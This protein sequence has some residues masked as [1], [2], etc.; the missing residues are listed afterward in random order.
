MFKKTVSRCLAYSVISVFLTQPLV[1][2]TSSASDP[3][4]APKAPTAPKEPTAPKPPTVRALLVTGG[5]CHDYENQKEIISQGLSK[6]VGNIEWTIVDYGDSRDTEADIYKQENWI[7]AFD[8][9]VHNECFGGVVDGDFVDSIVQAHID[10]KIPAIVV[11]C[12]MHSYRNAPTAD[13]WR[14][15]VGVTSRRHEKSKHSLNVIPTAEGTSD[16]IVSSIDDKWVTPNGE[17]YIIENVWPGTKVL[18]TVQ[19]QETGNKEP[20]IW[21]NT[22]RGVRVFGTTLGHHNETMQDEHW[23]QVVAAGWRWTLQY[24]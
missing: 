12:S 11:H 20:V 3:Q 22:Y 4:T 9:V 5:C 23:Q 24:P 17:L 7:D 2:N 15:L 21:T 19:S 10:K 6:Q 14:K 8:I 1:E 13:S 16:A 18:A